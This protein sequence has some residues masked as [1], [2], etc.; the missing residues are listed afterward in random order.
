MVL[1]TVYL[2]RCVR[3]DILFN[4]KPKTPDAKGEKVTLKDATVPLGTCVADFPLSVSVLSMHLN[5]L[6]I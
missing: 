3:Y 2:F 6:S 4:D 1:L 5:N